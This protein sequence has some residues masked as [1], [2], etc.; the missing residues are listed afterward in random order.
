MSTNFF[1]AAFSN[2]KTSVDVCNGVISVGIHT[3]DE[4]EVFYLSF[5]PVQASMLAEFLK[6]IAG[7]INI[8]SISSQR[9]FGDMTVEVKTDNEKEKGNKADAGLQMG[10]PPAA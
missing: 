1:T 10:E 8:N 3:E 2:L 9:M 7:H 5:S 6:N 4:R